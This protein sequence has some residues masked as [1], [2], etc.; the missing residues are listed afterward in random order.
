MGSAFQAKPP[1][2]FSEADRC[3]LVT[4]SLTDPDWVIH[5]AHPDCPLKHPRLAH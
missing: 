2:W 3:E 5:R 1:E 4:F